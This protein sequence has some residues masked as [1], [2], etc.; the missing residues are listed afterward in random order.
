MEGLD[1]ERLYRQVENSL[2]ARHG[3]RLNHQYVVTD[4]KL[5]IVDESTGR[6]LD[7]RKWHEGLHQAIEAKERL[8]ITE[9]TR[10][11]AKITMQAF[12]RL[13]THLSGMT[14]TAASARREFRGDF[15]LGVVRIPT[16]RPC[17][18]IELAP[19]IFATA[20]A[21]RRALADDVACWLEQGRAVLLGTPSVAASEAAGLDVARTGNSLRRAQLPCPRA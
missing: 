3:F 18:R 2:A 19:R 1:L 14:G 13:Y 21:K 17:R 8:S 20:A 5:A 10:T 12:F 7:G 4:G 16:H 6:I 11:A 15:A 9:S